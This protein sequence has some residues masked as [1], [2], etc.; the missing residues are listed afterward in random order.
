MGAVQITPGKIQV[1]INTKDLG[2]IGSV[3]YRVMRCLRDENYEGAVK[4]L[5]QF[6]KEPSDFPDFHERVER[7]VSHSI[8]LVRAIEMK[9]NFP[10][11]NRLTM[12]KRQDMK[13]RIKQHIDE[14]VYYMKKVERTETKLRMED[15][16][17]T[18]FII[19]A[20]VTSTFLITLLALLIEIVQ[21]LGKTTIIAVDDIFQSLVVWL[22]RVGLTGRIVGGTVGNNRLVDHKVGTAFVASVGLA[23]GARSVDGSQF[24]TF[25]EF[26]VEGGAPA[27]HFVPILAQLGQESGRQFFGHL[28]EDNPLSPPAW[29]PRIVKSQS[30]PGAHA[31][32]LFRHLSDHK[33]AR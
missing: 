22:S 1:M 29:Q 31:D 25:E 13:L 17:S 3:R 28:A 23:V 5:E 11:I 16:R 6:L 9:R 4:E 7:Y 8:S 15:L 30:G 18:V 21:G 24:F 12:A 33:S 32:M 19:R 27:F 10:G 20:I 14:L 2:K 26:H